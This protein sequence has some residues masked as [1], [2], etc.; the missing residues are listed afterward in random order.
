M[1]HMYDSVVP[2]DQTAINDQLNGFMQ[3]C[4]ISTANARGIL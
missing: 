4:S 2:I 3:D 1:D